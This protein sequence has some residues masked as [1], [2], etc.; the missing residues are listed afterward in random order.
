MFL[1]A[2]AAASLFSLV[3]WFLFYAVGSAI[4]DLFS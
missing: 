3:G 1:L 2:L 4:E